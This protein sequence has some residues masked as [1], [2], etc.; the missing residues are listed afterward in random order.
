M[1]AEGGKVDIDL[2]FTHT[3]LD[4]VSGLPF[5]APAYNP[6]NRV[7]LWAG[8]LLPEHTLHQVLGELMIAPL[9]PVPLKM[10]EGSTSYH[11]FHCGET[12]HPAPGVTVRTGPLNHPNRA[13]GYRVEYGGRAACLITD[14]EHPAE[15][16]DQSVLKLVQ[17]ADI[18]I[19]DAMYT[20]AQ[21][22]SKVGWGHSTW[23]MAVQIARAANVKRILL[24]HH[25]PTHD[26]ATMD[27]IGREAAAA[28]PNVE[29]AY[30]GMVVTMD[31]DDTIVSTDV[32][33]G[34]VTRPGG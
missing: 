26:D 10:L 5:F 9:F 16:M 30:E 27:E 33:E 25:E 31:A 15:G 7:R 28:F 20:E 34:I 14:T 24:I 2:F 32:D 22:A 3:H 18:M 6:N 8:H 4:H 12:L 23:N 11:D 17:D 1:L 13:T 19:Y 29:P 21:Y